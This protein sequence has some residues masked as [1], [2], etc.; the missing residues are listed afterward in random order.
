MPQL[1]WKLGECKALS[2]LPPVLAA[3]TL[4][5]IKIL[6][7]GAFD[8]D[9]QRVLSTVEQIKLFGHRLAQ[10]WGRRLVFV[11]AELI[12]HERHS[13]GFED[14]PLT[15][16][17]ERGRLAGAMVAPLVSINSSEHYRQAVS[18]FLRHSPEGAICLRL[19]LNDLEQGLTLHDLRA[20]L[21]DIGAS[22]AQTVLLVDGG[23]LHIEGVDDFVHLLAGRI[24]P[25]APEGLWLRTFWSGTT[26]PDKPNLRPGQVGSYQRTDWRLFKSIIT[27]AR[28]FPTAPMFSDYALEY[29]GNY[30][31]V[32]A[33]PSAHFRYSTEDDYF[34]FKGTTTKKPFGYEAIFSVA[35]LL[36]SADCFAGARF[37][38]GDAYIE[39][40]SKPGAKTGNA[41]VW[42]W[43]STDHHFR[44]VHGLLAQA[45]RLP[46][47]DVLRADPAEQLTFA[48]N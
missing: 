21:T 29:P 43:A 40:L 3:R 24:A 46:V 31:P 4:P 7:G 45:L 8:A 1:K 42:R 23:P 48:Y 11:D 27:N 13:L 32:Q 26:F 22:S 35:E 37:S 28:E 5:V 19:T 44:L 20:L 14:H 25:I 34:I 41:S 10:C 38:A 16:L 15:E 47:S 33:A 18:R 2:T 30:K 36:A 17:I 9:E 39:R 6:P 12:D